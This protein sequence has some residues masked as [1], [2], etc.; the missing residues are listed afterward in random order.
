[1]GT[2]TAVLPPDT[3]AAGLMAP[4][5]ALAAMS[6]A[7]SFCKLPILLAAP[8]SSGTLGEARGDLSE[9]EGAAGVAGGWGVVDEGGGVTVA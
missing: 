7:P 1:M 2:S 3:G 8:C 5:P 6:N 4:G 9:E